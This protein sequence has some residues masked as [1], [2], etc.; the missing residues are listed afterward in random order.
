MG[1]ELSKAEGTAGAKVQR[2]GFSGTAK[3]ASTGVRVR[4]QSAPRGPAG[5]GRLGCY[6]ESGGGLWKVWGRGAGSWVGNRQK[7]ARAE[8][9]RRV[10]RSPNLT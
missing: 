4:E 5:R 10:K 8:A 7:G 3:E 1:W 6:S 2:W 9:G